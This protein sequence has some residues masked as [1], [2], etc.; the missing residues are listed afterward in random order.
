VAPPSARAAAPVAAILAGLAC[1]CGGGRVA[2][3]RAADPAQ[4]TAG[5]EN[6][7][8][9]ELEGVAVL[10]AL[11][12]WR[13]QP[14][15]LEQ[16]LTPVDVTVRNASGR[17][18][19]LGPEAFTLAIGEAR[20]GVLPER[21]VSRALA[22]LVGPRAR[23]PPRAGIGGPTFPGYDSPDPNAPRSGA[24]VPP[25]GQWYASQL[26]SGMLESGRQ[27]SMLLFFGVP[28]RTLASAAIE[29][30]LVTDDGKALGAIRLP[31]DRR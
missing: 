4:A 23:P 30:E 25:S 16:R 24:A 17:T 21:E 20:H 10:V 6:E 9:A 5:L 28:A 12:G 18:L 27:T 31:F 2:P 22:G 19:R 1:A 3:L 13:G 11:G 7:A 29:I 15:D 8:Q 14:R 26:P